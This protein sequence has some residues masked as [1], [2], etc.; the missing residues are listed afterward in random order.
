MNIPFFDLKR[1]YASLQSEVE[2]ALL[3][4]LPTCG[5]VGGNAVSSFEQDMCNYLGTDY[6]I[7]C[8][9][10]TDA[11][12]LALRA[13]GIGSGDEVITTPFTFFATAEAIASVGAVPVF[14]DI[15]Y[16]DF[17]LDP[18]KI[19]SAITSKTRAVLPVHIFGAPC[20]M[21]AICAIAKQHQLWVIE[22][23]AQ[24]IGCIYHG[25]HIGT[26]ADVSCFSFYPTKNLGCMGDGGMVTTN[27]P[28]LNIILHALKEHGAGQIGIQA[29]ELLKKEVLPSKELPSTNSNY[30][31][32]KYLNSLIGYNSRLD[33]IQ[34]A[35]LSVKLRYLPMY[36]RR[37]AEI[38]A[39]YHK[40]L[41]DQVVKPHV[42][43]NGVHCWHQY[44]IRT[45]K[46]DELCAFLNQEG[47]GVGTF[48]PVP[49]HLQ[50][51]FSY[52]GYQQGSFPQAEQAAQ[53]TV[54]LPIFPEL[55]NE[56]VEYIIDTVNHFFQ[57][58]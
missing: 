28:D 36:T 7:S 29:R 32:Y 47:I 55:K 46:K 34:A 42:V 17:T 38:A 45:Q 15:R 37:R 35:I 39:M 6:S 24:A 25:A 13:C 12:V 58:A 9:S 49:L 56:E 31:P 52:L 23:A 11:L 1:Q 22:D 41:S 26:T 5:Y 43:G 53:E 20:D 16:D 2:S 30:D 54:C 27:H 4:L 14:V 33:A 10:G 50:P 48:Y 21:Q 3:G 8:A 40:G 51:A 57:K 18:T 44:V 19:E